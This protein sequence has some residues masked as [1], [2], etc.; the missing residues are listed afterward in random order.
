MIYYIFNF[1]LDKISETEVTIQHKIIESITLNFFFP[2]TT[3]LKLK[4]QHRRT[5]HKRP[6]LPKKLTFF[7]N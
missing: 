1:L 7:R 2:I 6:S 5:Q 3:L 4:P